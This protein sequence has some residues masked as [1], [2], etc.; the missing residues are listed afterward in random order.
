MSDKQD[1][2]RLA[3]ALQ[4]PE[5]GLDAWLEVQNEAEVR[6][7]ILALVSPT[8]TLRDKFAGQAMQGY[9]AREGSIECEVDDIAVDSYRLADRMLAER[10][11]S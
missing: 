9:C 7:A 5:G 1:A 2:T 11:A 6:A 10:S 8:E 3:A 4:S